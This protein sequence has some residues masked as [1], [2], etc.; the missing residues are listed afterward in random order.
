MYPMDKKGEK[1]E[2]ASVHTRGASKNGYDMLPHRD[3]SQDHLLTN[4][5]AIGNG[6]DTPLARS[7]SPSPDF[8]SRQPQLPDL[9]SA[10]PQQPRLPN[11][12]AP[13]RPEPQL[14]NIQYM[15]QAL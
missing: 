2:M 3:E 1:S 5:A 12:S 11:L 8:H 9:E 6:R 14:P 7:R 10:R 15:G 4:S 13:Q